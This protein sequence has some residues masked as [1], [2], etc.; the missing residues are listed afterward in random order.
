MILPNIGIVASEL[1]MIL[2]WRGRII[3]LIKN[4]KSGGD[5]Q[6]VNKTN[7]FRSLQQFSRSRILSKWF[8]EEFRRSK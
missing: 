4:N 5:K 2:R 6:K 7:P 1:I 3:L 8:T